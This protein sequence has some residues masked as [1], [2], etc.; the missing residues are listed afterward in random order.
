M[1]AE[2]VNLNNCAVPSLSRAGVN[3]CWYYYNDLLKLLIQKIK[4]GITS[5]VYELRR[6][7]AKRERS[8]DVYLT[9]GSLI[10]K[11]PQKKG[12]VYIYI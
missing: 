9:F 6:L 10:Q 7:Y 11:Q 12:Y 4:C 1:R 3:L 8:C 5:W 2:L